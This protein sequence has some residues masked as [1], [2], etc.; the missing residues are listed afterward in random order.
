M[1]LEFKG[2][3]LDAWGYDSNYGDGATQRVI[4]AVTSANRPITAMRPIKLK[5]PGM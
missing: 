1:K 5:T 3:Q 4:D 2:N